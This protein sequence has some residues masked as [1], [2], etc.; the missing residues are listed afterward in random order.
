LASVLRVEMTFWEQVP[1]LDVSLRILVEKLDGRLELETE[2]RE[3]IDAF[4]REHSDRRRRF[5]NSLPQ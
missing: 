3:L 2:L 5:R 1:D 4:I